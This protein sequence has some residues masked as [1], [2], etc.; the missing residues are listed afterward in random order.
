MVAPSLMPAPSALESRIRPGR[1]R[2]DT[3]GDRGQRLLGRGHV[4]GVE[5]AGDLQRRSRGPSAGGAAANFVQRRPGD[6]AATIWPAPL[7]LAGYSPAASMAATTSSGSPPSTALMPVGSSAQAAAISRPRTAAKVTA[8][9]AVS[10]PASA[11]AP[12]SPTLWPATTPTSPSGSCSAAT[13]AAATSRGWVLA[14]S[15]ISSA[16]ATVPRWTRSTPAS[17]DHQR[18]RASTPARSSHGV[19]KPGFWEPCPGARTASTSSTV[20]DTGR[21]LRRWRRPNPP[22]NVVGFLQ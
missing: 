6:P 16:S 10:T 15:R 3:T 13:R 1:G 11:A 18:S 12:I 4:R 22:T 9:S 7:R 19:R 2:R 8:A 21:S 14:V 20:P 5:R 17:T